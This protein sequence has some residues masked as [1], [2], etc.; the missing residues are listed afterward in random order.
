MEKFELVF[1]KDT[2]GWNSES[3]T[4]NGDGKYT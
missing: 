3:R 1:E 2:N 4:K